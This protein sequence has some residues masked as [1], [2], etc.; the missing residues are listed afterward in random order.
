MYFLYHSLIHFRWIQFRWWFKFRMNNT[1]MAWWKTGLFIFLF[2]CNM[3]NAKK[4][5]PELHQF[6]PVTQSNYFSYL[7]LQSNQASQDINLGD[8]YCVWSC[9]KISF[10]GKKLVALFAMEALFATTQMAHIHFLVV[11]MKRIIQNGDCIIA[12]YIW[13]WGS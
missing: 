3:L 13:K 2:F 9:N 6:T 7:A 12:T 1:L 4:I 5:W 8:N 10:V 11:T